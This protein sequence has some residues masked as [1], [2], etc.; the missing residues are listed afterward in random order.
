V[1]IISQNYLFLIR[2]KSQL[3][4]TSRKNSC[5]INRL[6]PHSLGL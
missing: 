3:I 4:G 2:A 1:N 6:A 5:K